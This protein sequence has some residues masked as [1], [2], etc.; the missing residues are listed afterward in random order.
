MGADYYGVL[1]VDKKAD[2]AELKKAYRKLAMKWHPDKNQGNPAAA[3]KFKLISEAYEV[4]SDPD[5][6]QIY[7]VYG[8]EGLKQGAPPPGAGGAG[9]GFGGG[10]GGAHPFGGFGGGGGAGGFT[11]RSAEDIFR[12]FFG[13]SMGGGG[14][15][16][17][18]EDLFGGGGGGGFGGHGGF[19][20]QQ[21]QH[22][23]QPARKDPDVSHALRCSLEELYAGATKRVK[24]TRTVVDHASGRPMGKEEVLTIDV[25]P[26]WKAGTKVRFEGK[27]DERAGARAGDIVFVIEEK[28][29]D[30][31]RRE[32]NNLV[33]TAKVNLADALCGPTVEVETLDK[34]KLSVSVSGVATP[35]A[36]K[37]VKGEGMPLSKDPKAKGDL[38]VRFE[39]RFP[40]KL[41]DDEK[42]LVRKALGGGGGGG[43]EKASPA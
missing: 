30:R 5:K 2:D 40:S 32:G 31:F 33:H 29:H 26:G 28:P 34:R 36:T 19:G 38:H 25:K 41:G 8:E 22:Q 12:E 17:G 27:G 18:F 21:H 13:A 42:A 11:P 14:G 24:L 15:G 3:D 39:I 20:Q 37:V 35:T 4:L 9:P 7:D 6:R 23:Q 10:G 1:G 43:G 16:G